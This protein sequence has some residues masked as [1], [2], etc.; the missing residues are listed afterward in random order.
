MAIGRKSVLVSVMASA[1]LCGLMSSGVRADDG[2]DGV[3][4]NFGLGRG[5]NQ[6]MDQ[7]DQLSRTQGGRQGQESSSSNQV[8]STDIRANRLDRNHD[9][10][11]DVHERQ[12]SRDR[13]VP[14]DQSQEAQSPSGDRRGAG[15]SKHRRHQ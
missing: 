14:L 3:S 15:S 1:A 10:V 7:Y 4:P 6:A 2:W 8:G 9:G 13:V 5:V 11:V 12:V